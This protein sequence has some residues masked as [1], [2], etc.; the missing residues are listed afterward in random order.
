[1]PTCLGVNF[2][3]E[4]F[5]GPE[6]LEK[7]GRKI[8]GKNSPS[9]FAEKFAGNFPEFRR[10]KIKI[11]PKSALQNLGLKSLRPRCCL[12]TRRD[13]KRLEVAILFLSHCG[14]LMLPKAFV[15]FQDAQASQPLSWWEPKLPHSLLHSCSSSSKQQH[16]Y[17]QQ[18]IRLSFEDLLAGSVTKSGIALPILLLSVCSEMII[19]PSGFSWS[20]G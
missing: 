2:G 20:P 4:V 1:M 7:Q 13:D 11:Y 14:R 15:G 19:F 12:T 18:P 10:A 6:A 16:Q 17:Q 5:G 8:R 3:R 9:K